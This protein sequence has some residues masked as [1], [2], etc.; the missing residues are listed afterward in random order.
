MHIALALALKGKLITPSAEHREAKG[1][2]SED[3]LQLHPSSKHSPI[4]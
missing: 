1:S 3:I 4:S 2:D